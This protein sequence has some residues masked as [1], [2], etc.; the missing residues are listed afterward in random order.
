M[1]FKGK[2]N[3]NSFR[4]VNEYL[5]GY[6]ELSS[7]KVPRL[8]LVGLL[9][10]IF[11]YI[12][13][14]GTISV[15]APWLV[16]GD[17][18]QHV[19]YVW[20]LYNGQ[21]PKRSDGI[22]YP[23]FVQAAGKYKPQAA[24]KSP[25]L[26]Y[27]IHAPFVG[28]LLN[29]GNWTLAIGVGRAINIFLGVLCIVALS[30]GGW[31]FGGSRKWLHAVTV[32]ALSVL[33]FRFTRLN[34]DYA[35][36]V[37]LVLM[38]TLSVIYSYKL[39]VLGPTRKN[40]ILITLIS[41]AGMLTKVSFIVFLLTNGFA[42]FVSY[43]LRSKKIKSYKDITK[44]L[45]PPALVVIAALAAS[46]WYY[47]IR[48]YKISGNWFSAVPFSKHGS[49]RVVRSFKDVITSSDLW[50]L[51]YVNYFRSAAISIAITSFSLAG[52]LSI[53]VN[54]YKEFIKNK[55]LFLSVCIMLL[56][57]L[58]IFCTQ[59]QHADGT[60]SINFRYMLPA[61]LPFGLFLSYG[62]NQIRWARGAFAAIA[63]IAMGATSIQAFASPISTFFKN[64]LINKFLGGIF[65]AAG[66]NHVPAVIT[67][68]IVL[69]F[70]AGCL[71]F[72]C[73]LFGLSTKKYQT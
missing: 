43:L 67:A 8:F 66:N 56:G 46:A 69:A 73:A 14:A 47:Y 52:I 22:Q 32:P 49:G 11:M 62:L 23:P 60:G 26:F 17:T 12:G 34:V 30:W 29:S 33:I 7:H 59:L 48:D 50:G 61:L 38:S 45:I 25:P 4:R 42:V 63:A 58:G 3:D 41:A 2:T 65:T 51:F 19:D 35:N 57:A 40:L 68:S 27:A 9:G 71:A 13:V 72:A 39:I 70:A 31:L 44:L 28:P 24:S 20:R 55:K 1:A 21:L 36:D 15:N 64:G 5:G 53:K 16:R 37:L 18:T 6:V 54:S 10:V